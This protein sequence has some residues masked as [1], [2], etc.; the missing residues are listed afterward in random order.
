MEIG[1]ETIR[2]FPAAFRSCAAYLLLALLVTLVPGVGGAS[3]GPVQELAAGGLH[4]CALD[5]HGV[6]CWG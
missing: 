2:R 4:T 6:T 1:R 5:D 3:A